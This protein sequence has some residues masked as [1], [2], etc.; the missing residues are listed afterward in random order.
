MSKSPSKESDIPS[1]SHIGTSVERHSSVVDS[2]CDIHQNSPGSIPP[3][4]EILSTALPESSLQGT[5]IDLQSA[6]T[7][8]L[9]RMDKM[10][11]NIAN[12]TKTN[13]LL[14]EKITAQEQDKV[15]LHPDSSEYQGDDLGEEV[16]PSSEE[17]RPVNTEIDLNVGEVVRDQAEAM[18]TGKYSLV[19]GLFNQNSPVSKTSGQ[20]SSHS[21]SQGVKAAYSTSSKRKLDDE[22]DLNVGNEIIG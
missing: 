17:L 8:L 9:S 3:R 18:S 21:P 22:N 7:L 12:V 10:E 13:N 6:L 19:A 16:R 5:S 1:L 20:L 2:A 4:A 11:S 14:Q 15:S